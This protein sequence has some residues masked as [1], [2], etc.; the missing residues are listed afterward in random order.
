MPN[1]DRRE[2]QI[3]PGRGQPGSEPGTAPAV[4]DS[5][6]IEELRRRIQSLQ[7]D[8]ANAD[9]RLRVAVRQRPF[10]A[11]GVAVAAGFLL[12]RVIRRL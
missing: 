8:F 4:D 12:G 1:H 9:R 10:V 2:Q 7:S 5:A 3:E 11:L 6:E